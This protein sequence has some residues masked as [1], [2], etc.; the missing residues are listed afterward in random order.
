M[1]RGEIWH[2]DLNPVVG[3]EQG[4]SRFVLIVSPQAFNTLIGLAIVVP[5][6]TGGGFVRSRGFAV[7][8]MG[9]G[10]RTSGV[11]IC[12]QPRTVDIK[13]RSGRLIEA[14]PS[15]IVDEVLAK[16]APIFE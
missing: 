1:N 10:T 2:L 6:T 14:V 15:F 3:H 7:S 4:G 12:A 16:L 9:A 13:G 8:L 5:I 11:I